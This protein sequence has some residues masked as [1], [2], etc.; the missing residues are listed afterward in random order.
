MQHVIIGTNKWKHE[1]LS[2]CYQTV[3]NNNDEQAEAEVVPSSSS[4]K[5]KFLKFSSSLVKVK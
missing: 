1:I 3:D 2:R 4:V 5:F